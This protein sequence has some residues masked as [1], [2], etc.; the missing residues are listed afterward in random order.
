MV[1]NNVTFGLLAAVLLS[2]C[3]LVGCTSYYQVTDPTTGKQYCTAEVK[4]RDGATILKDGDNGSR[5]TTQNSEGQGDHE[6]R[7]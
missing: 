1:M 5:V 3:T 4:Q 2:S 6:G 7:V